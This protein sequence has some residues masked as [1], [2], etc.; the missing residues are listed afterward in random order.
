MKQTDEQHPSA[1][2]GKTARPV[3]C[4]GDEDK[5]W[6][7]PRTILVSLVYENE[8]YHQRFDLTQ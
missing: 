2:F 8:F 3:R 6:L 1:G 4:G 5:E 7:W